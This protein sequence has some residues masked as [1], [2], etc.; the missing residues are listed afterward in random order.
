[1]KI[2]TVQTH[3]YPD[4]K[5]GTSG[6]RKQTCV[7]LKNPN[8]LEN[9]VQSIFDTIKAKGKTLVLGGDG[10]FYNDHALQVILKM[11][12]ANEVACIRI[13]QNGLFS[14]PAISAVIRKY[15]TDGGIILSASH[16]PAGEKGDFGIKVETKNGAPSPIE[17][18]DKIFEKTKSI[19]SFKIA[20]MPDIPLDKIGTKTY[21]KTKIMIMSSTKDYIELM[22][23]IFDFPAIK[24]LFKSGF[25][26]RYD[27]MNAVAG[28]YA[29]EI[30]EDI[31][32]AK[33]GSVVRGTPLPDFG[34][35]HPEPNLHYER[36]LVEFMKTKDAPDMAVASDGDADRYMILGRNF[37][38]APDNSLAI[39]VKYANLIKGYQSG[40]KGV[41]RSMPTAPA[42][43]RVA[44]KM[45]INVYETPTGWKY[46]GSLLD[47]GKITFCGEE[48]FGSGS[49]HIREKDGIWAILYWLNILAVTG[50][51]IQQIVTEH[52]KEFGRDYYLRHDFMNLP[53]SKAA[54]FMDDMQ[55][56]LKSFVGKK[57]AGLTVKDAWD[58]EYTDPVTKEKVE[59]CGI[60]ITLSNDSKIIY[61]LS[62]TGTVGATLRVYFHAYEEK[63]RTWNKKPTTVL[64]Q[65][66]KAAYEIAQI[67]KRFGRVRPNQIT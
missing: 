17:I 29:K 5:L 24:K 63:P 12:I 23:E 22:Q 52:W 38:V 15:K 40:V 27:A 55:N 2:N 1:M 7:F 46:F 39:L 33:K 57:V 64:K 31:L 54:D 8:Y 3:P 61:R 16:N 60:M 20:D 51:S 11:A 65:S 44:Q 67:K 14:T 66:I 47:A 50:K 10:R 30:F 32:G 56:N 34:G 25:T 43:D 53:S 62:N 35:L 9:F 6:L 45:K 4:Q 18:S 28:P 37:F 58:F 41:A 26:F 19:K 49:N 21:G 36:D 42:V 48:S 13:G 59:H